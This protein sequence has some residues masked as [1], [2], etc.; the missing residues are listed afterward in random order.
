[1]NKFDKII[2]TVMIAVLL[3]FF[4]DIVKEFC[5]YFTEPKQKVRIEYTIYT[6]A[7]ARQRSGVYLCSGKSFATYVASSKGSTHFYIFKK[8]DGF[9]LFTIQ[10]QSV[11][12]YEG[13]ADIELNK[14]E[15]IK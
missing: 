14:L 3:F 9:H 5:N 6:A 1:M 13:T 12:V 15:I 8:F 11:C 7:G 4:F 2:A 10:E